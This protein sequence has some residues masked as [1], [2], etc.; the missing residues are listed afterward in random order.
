MNKNIIKYIRPAGQQADWPNMLSTIVM[1]GRLTVAS[2]TQCSPFF[3]M[4][5]TEIRTPIDTTL[6]DDPPKD[7]TSNH[8]GIHF[9]TQLQL[10]R[11]LVK[12]N[13][14]DNRQAKVKQINLKAQP[15]NLAVGDTVFML[16]LDTQ[17][18][19][20]KKHSP[21]FKATPY[22][23]VEKRGPL[24]K[25]QNMYSGKELPQYYNRDLFKKY[26]PARRDE[27]LNRLRPSPPSNNTQDDANTAAVV[28]PVCVDNN[29]C[30]IR[31]LDPRCAGPSTRV[32]SPEP[33]HTG[34]VDIV[35]DYW[36]DTPPVSVFTSNVIG[37]SSALNP[38][39]P[40]FVSAATT[41]W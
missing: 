33:S 38:L 20:N 11:D 27:L 9:A 39:A 19:V 30:T 13:V 8:A 15:D 1:A 12:L 2:S 40:S 4:Y 34:A 24:L 5:G 23:I 32:T 41:S 26:T 17:P 31:P 28:A 22:F 37:T 16:D 3:C 36:C 35:D 18:G 29:Y 14:N 7:L 21:L 10:F 25:V 6:L